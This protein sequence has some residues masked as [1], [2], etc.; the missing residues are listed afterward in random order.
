MLSRRQLQ[1]FVGL[2]ALEKKDK[3]MSV[4]LKELLCRPSITTLTF[5]LN[6]LAGVTD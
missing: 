3:L 1:N 6:S 4:G 2:G 5:D